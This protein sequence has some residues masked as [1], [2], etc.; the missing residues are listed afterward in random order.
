MVER[1]N[2]ITLDCRRNCE[3]VR[4]DKIS[5]CGSIKPGIQCKNVQPELAKV[6]QAHPVTTEA[7]GDDVYIY[8]DKLNVAVL[9]NGA[10]ILKH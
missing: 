6:F 10:V 4:S 7:I 2:N 5:P 3:F 9:S 8:M 1:S